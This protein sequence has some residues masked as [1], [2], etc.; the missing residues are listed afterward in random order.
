MRNYFEFVDVIGVPM[1]LLW[2][3]IKKTEE[4][5]YWYIFSNL[6]GPNELK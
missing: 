6:S 4:L 3:S 2:R 5:K 1:L